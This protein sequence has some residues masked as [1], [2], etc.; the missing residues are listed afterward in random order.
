MN[1][2]RSLAIDYDSDINLNNLDEDDMW[3]LL[4]VNVKNVKDW[5]LSIQGMA[6]NISGEGKLEFGD[7]PDWVDD[8]F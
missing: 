2:L 6:L 8:W 4:K 3:D 7:I 1:D 5:K